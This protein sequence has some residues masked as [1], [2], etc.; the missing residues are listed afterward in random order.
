MLPVSVALDKEGNPTPPLAKK[1]AALGFPDLKLADLERASDG[2]AE[3][4]FYTYT[5]PGSALHA[6]YRPICARRHAAGDM[7][8]MR[9]NARENA[10]S[11]S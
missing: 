7:P 10:A 4:F 2:K 1:L 8:T 6:G 5:A 3:S 9:W 11:D